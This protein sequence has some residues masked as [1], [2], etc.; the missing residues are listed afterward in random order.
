LLLRACDPSL[1]EDDEDG[2]GQISFGERLTAMIRAISHWNPLTLTIFVSCLT[3]PPALTR[4]V[5]DPCF[6]CYDFESGALHEIGQILGLGTP[7]NIPRTWQ[8][9][10]ATCVQEAT[11]SRGSGCGI[12][13]A[14]W[15]GPLPGDNVYHAQIAQARMSGQRPNRSSICNNPW[16]SVQLGVPPNANGLSTGPTGYQRRPAQMESFTPFNPR[17]CLR[18][19]DLEA[20][21]VLYPDCGEAALS[22]PVCHKVQMNIGYVRIIC[23]VLFPF[24]VILLCIVALNSCVHAFEHREKRRVKDVAIRDFQ[25][26]LRYLKDTAE[27]RELKKAMS[28]L[29]GECKNG[30]ESKIRTMKAARRT[31][32]AP[33]PGQYDSV[34][35]LVS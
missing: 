32:A 16:A 33:R 28:Y 25:E 17:A 21:S 27:S 34:G 9:P 3:I 10:A 6:D 15:A 12:G 20:L 4:N 13:A 22:A 31:S 1:A 23:Y 18:D 35:N 14:S 5:F 24:I 19:D 30:Y 29:L 7:D 2:D 26:K 8:A 11:A